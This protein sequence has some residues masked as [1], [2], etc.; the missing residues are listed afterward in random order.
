MLK[1][2]QRTSTKHSEY[3][4][5][6]F[7]YE[8]GYLPDTKYMINMIL[9]FDPTHIISKG[10]INEFG[11]YPTEVRHEYWKFEMDHI[12]FYSSL[13]TFIDAEVDVS[14]SSDIKD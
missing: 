4:N 14:L 13:G 3:N 1:R 5:E 11:Y 7:G 10:F 8:M 6:D 9:F 12:P 2:A